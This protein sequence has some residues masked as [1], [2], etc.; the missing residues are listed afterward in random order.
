MKMVSGH[1]SVT[2][3]CV[4]VERT[5]NLWNFLLE[6][7]SYSEDRKVMFE[8]IKEVLQSCKDSRYVKISVGLLLGQG[9]ESC[10]TKSQNILIKQS[11]FQ[12]LEAS[13]RKL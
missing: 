13:E 5:M 7:K 4:I 3:R 9:W 10:V 6:C 2:R 11:V 1:R 12:F 8:D